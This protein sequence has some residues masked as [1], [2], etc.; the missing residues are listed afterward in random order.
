MNS[1]MPPSQE[2]LRY[3]E[4]ALKRLPEMVAERLGEGRG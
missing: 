3:A 1:A 2:E 4:Y